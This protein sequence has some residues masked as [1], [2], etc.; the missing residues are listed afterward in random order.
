[1]FNKDEKMGREMLRCSHI[2]NKMADSMWFIVRKKWLKKARSW[3]K[4]ASSHFVIQRSELDISINWMQWECCTKE[5]SIVK[6]M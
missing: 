6:S 1:M 2:G 3:G 4:C 5:I